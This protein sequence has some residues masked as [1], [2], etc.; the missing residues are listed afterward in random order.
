M[1]LCWNCPLTWGI[2]ILSQSE[3]CGNSEFLQSKPQCFKLTTQ[4]QML[5]LTFFVL[6]FLY[7]LLN[8]HELPIH[9]Q[10]SK[11]NQ[12]DCTFCMI[13]KIEIM[14]M[15]NASLLQFSHKMPC[16]C[17]GSSPCV[18]CS[19]VLFK[20]FL[21]DGTGTC[22]MHGNRSI[23]GFRREAINPGSTACRKVWCSFQ[24]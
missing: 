15:E 24:Q 10:A 6:I 2:S 19:W 12:K 8:C 17:W 9:L 11:L 14:Q 16:K 5:H 20:H 22:Y 13:Q 7:E 1:S 18:E 3:Y 23:W 4:R 21:R